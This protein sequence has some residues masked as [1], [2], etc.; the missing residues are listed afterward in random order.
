MATCYFETEA[1]QRRRVLQ[2]VPFL[3]KEGHSA[4]FIKI[5]IT[6]RPPVRVCD[7]V[8]DT[9]RHTFKVLTQLTDRPAIAKEFPTY[10]RLPNE[11]KWNVC[12]INAFI[13]WVFTSGLVNQKSSF[14]PWQACVQFYKNLVND[15][16]TTLQS[17][18][19]CALLY[20]MTLLYH[21]TQECHISKLGSS[22]AFSWDWCEIGGSV[23]TIGHIVRSY[24]ITHPSQEV[25]LLCPAGHAQTTTVDDAMI[26]LAPTT[27]KGDR[28][29]LQE[30]QALWCVD[31]IVCATHAA[32]N[33]QQLET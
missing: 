27:A 7:A 28:I 2:R 3:D 19:L 10:L 29:T 11:K 32:L 33:D 18:G 4:D 5:L 16:N 15:E 8:L 17:A 25:Y 1:T 22:T 13:Q 9:V 12:W 14:G 24:N 26:L 23:T 21:R 30:V 6:E 20:R 31:F